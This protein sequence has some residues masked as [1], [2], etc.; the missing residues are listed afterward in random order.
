MSSNDII[1]ATSSSS[2]TIAVDD[3]SCD[4]GRIDISQDAG[5]VSGINTNGGEEEKISNEKCTSCDQKL[6]HTKVDDNTSNGNVVTDIV[7]GDVVSN[8]EEV[9]VCANCGKEGANNTCNK[10]KMVKYCN[11]A[12]KKK[13]RSKHKKD[14]EEHIRRATELRDIELFKEPPL[15]E[16]CPIC[17][18]RMPLLCS[19]ILLY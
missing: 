13:H 7:S 5:D 2:G 11:A 18:L 12:C 19:G 14:C 4:I 16:D 17:F 9:S 10:C 15:P 1:N 8:A 3:I 6:D